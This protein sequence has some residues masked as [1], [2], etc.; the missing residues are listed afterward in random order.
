MLKFQGQIPF[1]ESLGFELLSF[2]NGAAEIAL[3]PR[4]EQ[5]NSWGVL[6]GGVTMT[7]L[8]VAMAQAARSP[9][10]GA[11]PDKRGV[12]TVEMKTSF[13][14]PGVGRV[15][16]RG[17]VLRKTSTLVFCEGSLFGNDEMLIA[18]A[19]GTFKYLAALPVGGR[20]LQRLNASD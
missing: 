10:D 18:H 17:R 1:V 11:A 13:T 20:R 9:H 4:P 19:T 12:V 7:L 2:A 6:H 15:L 16:A 8:D 14:G 5:M 3:A